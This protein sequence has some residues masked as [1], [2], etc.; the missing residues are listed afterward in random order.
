M[1]DVDD[2]YSGVVIM[3]LGTRK[4]ELQNM[5]QTTGKTRL[6][7]HI[8]ARGLIGYRSEFDHDTHGTGVMSS[9]FKEYA[10]HKVRQCSPAMV[11]DR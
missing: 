1:V 8:P 2:E 5:T 6:L 10:P 4:G 3:K 11:V 9:I 7:F